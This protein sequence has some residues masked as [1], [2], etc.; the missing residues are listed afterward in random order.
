MKSLFAPLAVMSLLAGLSTL[1]AQTLR[2]LAFFN[3]AKSEFPESIAIDQRGNLYL[4]LV[5]AGKIKKVTPDGVQSDFAT[6]ADTDLLGVVFD[7]DGNLVVAGARGIWKVSPNG[8][9]RLFSSVPGHISLN[10]FAYDQH[11]NLLVSDDNK[12]VIW[13]VDPKGNASV[14][15]ADPLYVAPV[16]T[17]PFPVGVNGLA[18]TRDM[19]TLHISNTSAGRLLAVDVKRDGSAGP[20]RI[21]ASDPQLIGADGIEVDEHDNT[22]VAVN[23]QE[24]IVRVS[25][26]G[27]LSTVAKGDLLSFPT[28]LVFGRGRKSDTLFICNN[29]DAFFSTDPIGEGVLKLDLN[30]CEPKRDLD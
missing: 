5:F 25:K 23:I 29:G 17:F 14:W 15:S 3:G 2:P 10:D 6:I 12:F 13:K 16:D 20:V 26:K 30:A 22:Y 27:K 18:F 4:S 1:N 7:T 9:V 24:R 28:S 8:A 19:K 11:G 21:L